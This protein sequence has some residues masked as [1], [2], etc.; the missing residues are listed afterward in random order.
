[1]ED[2]EEFLEEFIEWARYCGE[3]A[4]YVFNETNEAIKRFLEER[5]Q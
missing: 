3:D 2:R 4:F 1:M 5:E